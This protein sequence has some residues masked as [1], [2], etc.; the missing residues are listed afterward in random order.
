MCIRDRDQTI[1]QEIYGKTSRINSFHHQ[2]I[3]D[4]ADG[5]EV[6]AR[7]P[8]DDVIEAVQSTD[9]S[10]FLGVQWHPELRFDKSPADRKPVSYT[11]L[12]C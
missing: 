11:H 3:K 9:K 10:R 4:L 1:L 6:I 2:S 5:L 12:V 7:D 8:K